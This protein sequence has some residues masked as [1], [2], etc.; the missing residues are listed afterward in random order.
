[1]LSL[2]RD[3]PLGFSYYR[4]RLHQ[5]FSARAA[6]TDEDEITKALRQARSVQ[7]GVCPTRA[8]VLV[9]RSQMNVADGD[10]MSRD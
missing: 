6:L 8:K 4:N 9:P 7:K 3:Y 2:G 5:A 1:M 10:E